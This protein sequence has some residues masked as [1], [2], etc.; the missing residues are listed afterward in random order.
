MMKKVLANASY[1]SSGGNTKSVN[2]ESPD[3]GYIDMLCDRFK[4]RGVAQHIKD[5]VDLQTKSNNE[6]N[7][8]TF[9]RNNK[10]NV[11]PTDPRFK[12]EEY[13][14]QKYMSGEDFAIYYAELRDYKMPHF[15]V[16]PESEYEEA[17]EAGTQPKKAERLTIK[18]G[19]KQ[20]AK[21]LI[22]NINAE[23]FTR[24]ANAILATDTKEKRTEE[25]GEKFPVKTIV[26]ILSIAM[27]LLM[28][29]SSSVMVSRAERE[30][31]NLKEELEERQALRDKLEAQLEVKNDMLEIRDIAVNEYGMVSGDFVNSEYI[32]SEKEE[33]NEKVKK[34]GGQKFIDVLL[35]ALDLKD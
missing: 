19:L 28:V 3:D 34:P 30:L 1:S 26:V 11:V 13:N 33:T 24:A 22:A 27:S 29:I 16:R 15:Y 5:D 20:R 14:G 7:R 23:N 18:K 32:S 12:N 8:N 35:S 2:T 10:N 4:N 9:K 6:H 25:K 31:S 17:E 21:K